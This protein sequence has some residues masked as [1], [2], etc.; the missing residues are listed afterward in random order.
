MENNKVLILDDEDSIRQFMKINLEY[1]GYQTVEAS[2]GEEAIKVFEQEDPSVAILDV[3]LPGISGY[4][5]CQVIRE[6]SPK[7]GIIMVSAKSQDID[8]IL[9]L[10]RGADD[11]IIKPFNPQ[12]L[13]LR[14]RSLMRRVNLTAEVK[15]ESNSKTLTDG[16]FTLDLYSKTF[17][18]VENEIDVTPT[19]FAILKNF[20]QNKGKAMT[21]NEI[22]EATWGENY[23]NDTKIVDV[24]IRRIRAK[25]EED[26]AKPQYIET[27]WGTGYRW[28]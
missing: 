20:I 11:Y 4:E 1:Q 8:K 13:I 15:E 28:K 7:T 2:S 27:V 9:G 25:I 26:P 12:E 24:N 14:V 6:K 3:M 17:Y 22:M 23:S 16:P 21:R 18:K 5:V 10:E 19:E